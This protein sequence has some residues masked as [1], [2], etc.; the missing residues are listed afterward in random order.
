MHWRTI[1]ATSAAGITL[2]FVVSICLASQSSPEGGA[3]AATSKAAS[4]A[5]S[6]SAS[7]LF[8][9]ASQLISAGRYSEAVGMLHHAAKLNPDSSGI[10]HYLGY[11]L[12][13][14]N[15][16]Q[17]ARAEFETAHR[18]NPQNP[19]TCYFLARI[20]QSLGHPRQSIAYY[21]EILK[22]GPAVYDTDQRL[23]QAHLDAG[24]IAQARAS[25]SAALKAQ[26]WNGA[27]YYQ[28]GRID[29]RRHHP[30]RARAE[31]AA[32]SRL[33]NLNHASIQRLLQLS[34]AIRNHDSE[35]IEALR[36]QILS[37]SSDDPEILDSAGFLLGEGGLYA[38]AV[39][40][41]ERAVKLAP[42]T[43]EPNYNLGL[44]LLKLGRAGD[45]QQQLTQALDI[46]PESPDVNRLLAILYV[47]EG[48]NKEAIERL[49]ALSQASPRDPRVLAL[50]GEQYLAGN[51]VKSAIPS[52]AS[53]IRLAPDQAGPRYLLIEAYEEEF[54]Y[55]DALRAAQETA[56]LFP[57]E[58]RA[59]YEVGQQYA[60]L[61][62]YKSALP[63]ARRAIQMDASLV[64]AY[65]LVGEIES[66]N[67]N[68]QAALEM[69]QKARGLNP[70]DILALRGIGDNLISLGRYPEA[71]TETQRALAVK[72]EDADL[73]FNLMKAYVR[74]GRRQEAAQAEATFQKLHAQAV[75]ARLARTP[76]S[77]PGAAAGVTN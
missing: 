5:G 32:A 65:N 56:H 14:L 37:Q 42:E 3:K 9:Q 26:P 28:M 6:A 77:F 33:K 1:R 63:A 53:A 30:K 27:L 60:N 61:G 17:D 41:L 29:E 57:G 72:P 19:Y 23:G 38:E 31:F 48:R 71:L 8:S 46:D 36:A 4:M 76:K 25:I 7:A 24:D 15:R 43:F 40:P 75:A 62:D 47:N 18:L 51:Y 21:Q 12:W 50:L 70:K 52:L 11:A 69:Y 34:Q 54:D 44:T 16:W 22:L 39:E 74:L 58:A 66:K 35:Q 67:G 10:H 55:R 64:S 13:K 45:A 59:V 20:A 68:F 2:L 73:Y 49:Q